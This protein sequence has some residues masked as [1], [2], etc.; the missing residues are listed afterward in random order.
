[1]GYDSD[2]PEAEGDTGQG[3][4]SINSIADMEDLF[5]GIPL[6]K[7]SVSLVASNPITAVT[8]MA[9]YLVV[10]KKRGIAWELLSGTIQNDFL[11]ETTIT[12]APQVLPPASSFKLSTDLVEYC[13]KH[14]PKWNPI[15]YTGY[16]YRESG[17]DAVQEVAI[18][19]ANALAS[20]EEMLNRGYSPEFFVPRLSFSFSADND[21]FEEIAKYRAAR[22]LWCKLISSKYH[23][24]DKRT[25]ALRYHVQTAGWTLTVQEPFNNTIRAAYQ[26]LAA[27]LGGAQSIHVDGYDE[28]LCIPS[29]QAALLPLRTQQILQNEMNVTHTIDPLGGS[30]FLESLTNEMESKIGAYLQQIEELGGIITA[31]E[32]G[33]LHREISTSAYTIQKQVEKAQRKIVGVNFIP[34]NEQRIEIFRPD[35]KSHANQLINLAKLKQTRNSKAVAKSLKELNQRLKTGENVM[36]AIIRA[37]EARATL[38]EISNS[39]RREYG[40]W[41]IPLF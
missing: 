36:D 9:M 12:T 38:G 40:T 29:E 8:L 34:P 30:Y 33:W 16:S 14:V 1:R 17:A 18:V 20:I 2:A 15:S 3:G 22:R 4:V 37:V 13:A 10:A 28:A 25:L 32:K 6:D 23:S 39:L 31:V 41:T 26:A 35:P 21:F 24:K 19:F 11:M 5:T 27:V 7:I